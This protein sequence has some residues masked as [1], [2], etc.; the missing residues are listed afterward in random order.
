[1]VLGFFE[2]LQIF[3]QLYLIKLLRLLTGQGYLSSSTCTV[4]LLIGHAGLLHKLKS[5]IISGQIFD[6]ISS[7]LSYRWL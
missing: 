1:M 6:L 7:F 2:Q 5:Y 3:L 4:R